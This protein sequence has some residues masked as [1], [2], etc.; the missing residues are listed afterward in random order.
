MWE[1]VK[2]VNQ[3]KGTEFQKYLERK[4]EKDASLFNPK[5][6]LKTAPMIHKHPE[7]QWMLRRCDQHIKWCGE[8]ATKAQV[9]NFSL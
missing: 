1:M 6:F 7:N 9:L 5:Y 2:E 4:W 3:E 8:D